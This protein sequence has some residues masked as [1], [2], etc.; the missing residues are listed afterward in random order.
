MRSTTNNFLRRDG[1]NNMEGDIN[2]DNHIK[3]INLSDPTDDGD[4]INKRYLES[5][6]NNLFRRD[7]TNNME[8]DLNADN[9][10]IINVA[11]PTSAQDA[12]TKHYADSRKP[13]ITIWA[14]EAGPLNFRQYE[15]SFGSGD[16]TPAECGYCMPAPGRILR[17]SISSTAE[18]GTARKASVKMAINGRV[19][20]NNIIIK[21]IELYSHTTMFRP[22]I[23]VA[24]N[25]RI[26]FQTS[27]DTPDA[28]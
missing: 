25:D 20:R 22:P 6:T 8:G 10:K 15:W 9:H 16:Y 3:I 5:I 26:N 7:G 1:T 19:T 2:A 23:E 28:T 21:P 11:N 24:Q 13:V 18:S 14:Q 17:G 4:V 12:V 27:R